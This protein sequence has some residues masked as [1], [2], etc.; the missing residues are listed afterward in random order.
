MTGT[1][2]S[3]AMDPLSDVLR[4]V[5]LRGAVFFHV[6]CRGEW[7]TY[8]PGAG[9]LAPSLAPGAEHMMEYHF[10]LKGGGW[11]AVDG[12]PPVRLQE[13]D[14]VM[15]PHGDAHVVS[16]APG[17][18]PAPKARAGCSRRSRKKRSRCR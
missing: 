4:S 2:L 15:L 13:G 5:R 8:A 11:V 18:P 12:L 1:N 14:C 3:N 17:L 7:S 10:F 16:S 6:S 9:L